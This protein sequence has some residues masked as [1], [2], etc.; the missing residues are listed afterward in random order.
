MIEN[1]DATTDN[2]ICLAV[3]VGFALVEREAAHSGGE[4]QCGA[5]DFGTQYVA[6]VA[7]VAAGVAPLETPSGKSNS[8]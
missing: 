4:L 6:A 2:R 8:G 3:V 5:Q 1:F 7:A